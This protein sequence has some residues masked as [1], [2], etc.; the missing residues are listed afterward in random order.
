MT[1]DEYE[2]K[3]KE[4]R[5]KRIELSVKPTIDKLVE[6]RAEYI[7]IGALSNSESIG[8]QIEGMA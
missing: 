8:R 4:L 7:A 2:A 5:I 1:M 3:I 6:L